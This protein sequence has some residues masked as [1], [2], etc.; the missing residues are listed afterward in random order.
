VNLFLDYCPLLSDEDQAK[1]DQSKKYVYKQ[2]SNSIID[3][4]F[5]KIKNIDMTGL[6]DEELIKKIQETIQ[7]EASL[8]QNP[9]FKML[10][11]KL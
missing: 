10:V 7:L 11:N 6:K 4:C 2:E 8:T 1:T 5:N 3:E 9:Y